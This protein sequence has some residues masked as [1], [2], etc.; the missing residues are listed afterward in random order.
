MAFDVAL[1]RYMADGP[2]W[3]QNGI[4]NN[5]CSRSWW[6]NAIYLNNFLRL[7]EQ[8]SMK[9]AIQKAVLNVIF[10]LVHELELVSCQRLPVLRLRSTILDFI[11]E[12][13]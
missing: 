9:A 2:F 3:N 5:Y 6:T 11:M 10:P 1:Y 4:E 12:V 13:S 8:V 7:D